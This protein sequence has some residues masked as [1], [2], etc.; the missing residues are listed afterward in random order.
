MHVCH[1]RLLSSVERPCALVGDEHSLPRPAV[2]LPHLPRHCPTLPFGTISRCRSW[3]RGQR[4]IRQRLLTS[5]PRH[6]S[7]DTLRCSSEIPL[8][9][10]IP[11][12]YDLPA[13]CRKG[14][15]G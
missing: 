4:L 15:I 10:E 11:E 6:C 1:W 2:R 8:D 5:T 7:D 3:R 14:L 13:I 9:L 12:P